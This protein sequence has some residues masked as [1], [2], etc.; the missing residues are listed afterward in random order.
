MGK[1]G[2][3]SR[4]WRR[5]GRGEGKGHGGGGGLGRTGGGGPLDGASHCA[6]AG[7][8]LGVGKVGDGVEVRG[9]EPAARVL[10]DAQLYGGR[11]RERRK[12]A[13][14]GVGGAHL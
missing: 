10:I 2:A 7:P 8:L 1:R 14:V 5:Q 12:G 3:G 4:G 13:S 6:V 11:E 9:D